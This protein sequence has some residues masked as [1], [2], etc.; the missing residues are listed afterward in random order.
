MSNATFQM[1]YPIWIGIAANLLFAVVNVSCIGSDGPWVIAWM[2]YAPWCL[3]AFWVA[4]L[5]WSAINY[6]GAK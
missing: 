6:A 3:G 5:C 4:L 1:L 2:K